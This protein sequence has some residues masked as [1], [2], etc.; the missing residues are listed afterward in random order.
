[1]IA[2]ILGTVSQ[3]MVPFI[4]KVSPWFYIS[5][6]LFVAIQITHTVPLVPDYFMEE[7]YGIANTFRALFK[8][9]GAVLGNELVALNSSSGQQGIFRY[10][11]IYAGLGILCAISFALV[12]LFMKDVIL[13][14]NKK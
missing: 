2:L 1:M 10:Q 11:N 7:S 12:V 9:I 3:F 8:T 6:I 13:E 14:K 4:T 5:R